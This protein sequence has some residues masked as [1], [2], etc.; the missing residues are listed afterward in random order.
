MLI[1]QQKNEASAACAYLAQMLRREALKRNYQ[2]I[3]DL[4]LSIEGD[5]NDVKQ[6]IYTMLNKKC[7]NQADII[8][9]YDV[10]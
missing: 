6:S 2:D 5:N 1:F 8:R 10:S 3:H 7:L 4:H 9:L